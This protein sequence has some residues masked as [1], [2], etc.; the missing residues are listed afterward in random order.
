MRPQAKR[1]L[2]YIESNL[3]RTLTLREL[4]NINGLST[5]HFARM[6]KTAMGVT[7]HRYVLERR[8]E[9]AKAML[10]TTRVTLADI[11]LS[12]GFCGQ[13][14]FTT[15]FRRLTGMT[16]AEFQRYNHALR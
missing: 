6:F 16:P 4:A 7:P 12:A 13:S 9:R 10:R 2:E 14:H 1:V 8:V 11:G 5:Y 3:A 15:A